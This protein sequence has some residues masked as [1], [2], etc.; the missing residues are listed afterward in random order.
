MGG[1]GRASKRFRRRICVVPIFRGGSSPL[2][3]EEP[4]PCF[5]VRFLPLPPPSCVDLVRRSPRLPIGRSPLFTFLFSFLRF[6]IKILLATT[7]RLWI[8][9]SSQF[10]RLVL[11]YYL[12]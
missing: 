6:A 3:D 2:S 1:G 12:L 7:Q 8:F 10:D 11:Y 5:A 4:P 9:G